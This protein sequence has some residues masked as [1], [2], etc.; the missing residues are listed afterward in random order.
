MNFKILAL[1]ALL[2]FPSYDIADVRVPYKRIIPKVKRIEIVK[3]LKVRATGYYPY[4]ATKSERHVE[5]G[6]KDKFGN[7]IKTMQHNHSYVTVAVD[8]KV[9]PLK[10]YFRIKELPNKLFYA[11]DVGTKIRGR[12]IDIAVWDKTIAWNLPKHVTIQ[13]LKESN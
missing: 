9:I 12:K 2:I 1:I 6:K 5:G 3:E 11:C 8:K 10:T 7:P 4:T 13:F